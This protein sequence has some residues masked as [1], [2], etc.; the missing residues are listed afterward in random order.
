GLIASIRN[1]P[2]LP[3]VAVLV[4]PPTASLA[5]TVAPTTTAPLGSVIV[6]AMVPLLVCALKPTPRNAHRTPMISI[7]VAYRL[8]MKLL[9]CFQ[10]PPSFCERASFYTCF[11]LNLQMHV[12]DRKEPLRKLLKDQGIR[13][14]RG[15]SAAVRCVSRR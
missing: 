4:S 3:V 11:R 13:K 1:S 14:R 10:N 6:P 2:L 5:V 7:R 12:N 15:A 9:L 8:A